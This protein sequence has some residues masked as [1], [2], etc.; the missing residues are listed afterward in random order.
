MV[1]A[2]DFDSDNE[3]S[4]DLSDIGKQLSRVNKSK[5]GLIKLLKVTGTSQG[6]F[7]YMLEVY[8]SLAV[9][10]YAASRRCA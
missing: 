8:F 1:N 5:D 9:A 2:Y 3:V 6:A 7:K 10:C 4:N